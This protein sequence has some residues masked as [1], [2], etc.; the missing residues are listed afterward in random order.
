MPDTIQM[1][2]LI[3][4]DLLLVIIISAIAI[5]IVVAVWQNY[6]ED[7]EHIEQRINQPPKKSFN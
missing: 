3:H 5:A 4:K 7:I 6:V 2:R 1:K